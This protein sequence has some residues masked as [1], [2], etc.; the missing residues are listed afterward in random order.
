[1][2]EGALAISAVASQ[3]LRAP[4]MARTTAKVRGRAARPATKETSRSA[5]SPSPSTAI[6]ALTANRNPTG[7]ICP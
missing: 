2:A 4:S 6:T 7:A 1:M 5:C 3:A